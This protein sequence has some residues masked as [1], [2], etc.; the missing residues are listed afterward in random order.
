[1]QAPQM[2]AECKAVGVAWRRWIQQMAVRTCAA[3]HLRLTPARAGER[4]ARLDVYASNAASGG[5]GRRAGRGA[6]L[7]GWKKSPECRRRGDLAAP[8]HA[9]STSGASPGTP[10]YDRHAVIVPNT[11]AC[12]ASPLAKECSVPLPDVPRKMLVRLPKAPGP[13]KNVPTQAFAQI[14]GALIT[15]PLTNPI[16]H[17]MLFLSQWSNINTRTTSFI[18]QTLMVH[19]DAHA[20]FRCLKRICSWRGVVR[21][22]FPPRSRRRRTAS[23]ASRPRSSVGRKP[24]RGAGHGSWRRR[25]GGSRRCSRVEHVLQPRLPARCLR[26]CCCGRRSTPP[27]R[28]RAGGCHGRGRLRRRR[29]SGR[30]ARGGGWAVVSL[31]PPAAL[32]AGR[33]GDRGRRCGRPRLGT[34]PRRRSARPARASASA[35]GLTRC[36]RAATSPRSP[37]SSLAACLVLA[38]PGEEALANDGSGAARGG[39]RRT[40]R[41]ASPRSRSTPGASSIEAPRRPHTGHA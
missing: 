21:R 6:N 5:E 35:R 38:Q 31:L 10:K 26:C 13:P 30:G 20:M 1:M 22:S 2:Q 25:L 36:H 14:L 28:G 27:G 29:R 34:A 11:E 33:A 40:F 16:T 23:G 19:M 4:E 37:R 15:P 39:W 9:S 8:L 17:N 7:C 32:A 3:A 24:S 12:Q 41:R 18:A